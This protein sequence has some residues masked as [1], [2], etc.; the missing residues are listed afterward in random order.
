MS[1]INF[2][3]QQTD[4]S[5]KTKKMPQK[6]CLYEQ[7]LKNNYGQKFQVRIKKGD[8]NYLVLVPK[9]PKI[10]DRL[11]FFKKKQIFDKR[12][13]Q[14]YL[15]KIKSKSNNLFHEQFSN[16][17]REIGANNNTEYFL[18]EPDNVFTF[19]FYVIW[20]LVLV[21]LGL[22]IQLIRNIL[23]KGES[24]SSSDFRK[25]YKI[26]RNY[27]IFLN[28]ALYF[29]CVFLVV[30]LSLYFFEAFL[31][32]LFLKIPSPI[33]VG[34]KFIL[35]IVFV[36]LLAVGYG[37]V[38]QGLRSGPKGTYKFIITFPALLLSL[39]VICFIFIVFKKRKQE[40]KSP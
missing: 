31:K 27:L 11:V 10:W 39:I 25:K 35:P 40:N 5:Q 18:L 8:V 14:N 24:M 4:S 13:I 26:D 30:I 9:A 12:G 28:Y 37:I 21:F 36:I 33:L 29:S 1:D 19:A 7:V 15:L 17:A 38:G 6:K 16:I 2:Q 20:I 34:I 22:T 23:Q 32:T 3:W